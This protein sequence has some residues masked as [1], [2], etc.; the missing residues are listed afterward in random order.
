MIRALLRAWRDFR[1]DQA[2]QQI[3]VALRISHRSEL[4][5]HLDQRRLYL[6]GDPPKWAVLACPCGTGHQ[7]DLNLSSPGRPRWKVTL[8][9]RNRPSVSP[10]IHVMSERRCHFWLDHGFIRWCAITNS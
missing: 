6:I 10:S 9:Y 5:D 8:D 4:P 7:I 3:P 1:R 2:A